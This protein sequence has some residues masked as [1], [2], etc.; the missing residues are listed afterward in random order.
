MLF[1]NDQWVKVCLRPSIAAS[2]RPVRGE[3]VLL[4]LS[5][6]MRGD[7]M[8]YGC[9]KCAEARNSHRPGCDACRAGAHVRDPGLVANVPAELDDTLGKGAALDGDSS[10]C[11]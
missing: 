10:R 4:G 1:T 2:S 8:T 11:R 9:S 3:L 6:V 5:A 7:A